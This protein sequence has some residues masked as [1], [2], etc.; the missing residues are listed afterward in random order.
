MA[1]LFKIQE[2]LKA[3]KGLTKKW[4]EAKGNFE[5]QITSAREELE[6]AIEAFE[7]SPS[8]PPLQKTTL[9][10]RSKLRSLFVKRRLTK[11]EEQNPV[12]EV[13]VYQ[14]QIL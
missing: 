8:L 12:A 7:S 6:K 11:T 2:K 1:G 13:R 5:K 9:E 4:V 3:V 10:K 14:F